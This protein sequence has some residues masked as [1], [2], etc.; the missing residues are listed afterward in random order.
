LEAGGITPAAVNISRFIAI[1]WQLGNPSMKPHPVLL[2][3][4]RNLPV[5]CA[6]Q[7]IL[8]FNQAKFFV[9]I[10]CPLV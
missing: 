6:M 3:R 5:Y 1:S 4:R 10:P 7:H 2:Q 9:T 8:H